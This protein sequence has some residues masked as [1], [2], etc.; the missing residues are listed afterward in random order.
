MAKSL[1]RAEIIGYLG[2]GPELRYT[3]SSMPVSNFT[4]ATN[5]YQGRDNPDV[6]T[7]HRVVVWDKVAEA[8]AQYLHGG[9]QVYVSGRMQLKEWEDRNGNKRETL[10]IVAD[11][12]IF[13][14]DS[15]RT[16]ERRDGG[17]FEGRDDPPAREST[18]EGAPPG[19]G[20]GSYKH[21]YPDDDSDIPF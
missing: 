5:D 6:T 8:C 10:E 18:R 7:W 20:G 4:V 15:K 16:Q 17:E 11:Q 21:Q 12:V 1:N 3:A 13:L 2:H 19:G 14:G 9:S